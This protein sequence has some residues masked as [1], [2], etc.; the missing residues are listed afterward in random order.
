M[1]ISLHVLMVEDSENDAELSIRL[2]SKAGYEIDYTRVETP[3]KCRQPCS[4][5]LG[6]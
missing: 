4:A 6:M 5:S 2:L 1:G 3:L